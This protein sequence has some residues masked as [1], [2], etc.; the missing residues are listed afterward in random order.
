[1]LGWFEK[2]FTHHLPKSGPILE[3]GCGLGQYVIALRTRGY[4]ARGIDFA[5]ET[6]Q[7][8]L[9]RYPKLPVTVGDATRIDAPDGYYAGYISLGVVEHALGG[10]EPFLREACRVLAPDGIAIITVPHFNALRRLKAACGAYRAPVPEQASFYQYAFRRTDFMNLVRAAGF[11]TIATGGYDAYKT[12]RDEFPAWRP[13]LDRRLGRYHLGSALQQLLSRLPWTERVFG[14]ML[15]L[16]ARKC[17][18]AK[19]GA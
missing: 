5:A 10:P 17:G 11:E 4:D 19:V 6:V 18:A 9:R 14:H 13:L 15:L 16:V 12:L 8:I 7:A 1:M 2:P 3:A